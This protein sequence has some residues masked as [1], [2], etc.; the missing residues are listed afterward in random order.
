[1]YRASIEIEAPPDKIFEFLTDPKHVQSW[2][3]AV[4]E[5]RPLP[6]G[7][8]HVG[9]HVG[10]TVMEYGRRFDVD[11]LVAA[12]TRNE[13]IAYRLEAPKASAYVEYRLV[14]WGR[15]TRVVS[16][17]VTRPKGFIGSLYPVMKGVINRLA[18]WKM[19]SRLKLL[20]N[21]VESHA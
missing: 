9:T 10:A 19:E 8:L 3:P 14:Q 2:Q 6:P 5:T 15:Y 1:M 16:S 20:R 12:M 4:V 21:A 11:L 18:K 17:A 7:G 13:H